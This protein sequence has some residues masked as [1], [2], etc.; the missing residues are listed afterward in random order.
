[1]S[2]LEYLV[3]FLFAVIVAGIVYYSRRQARIMLGGKPATPNDAAM[4]ELLAE[5]KRTN[6]AIEK[7]VAN[8]ESRIER[9]EARDGGNK[10]GDHRDGNDT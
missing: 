1:M 2:W 9:I 4:T 3:I 8:H 7:L 6:A 10:D 5:M